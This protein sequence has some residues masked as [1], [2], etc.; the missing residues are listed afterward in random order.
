MDAKVALDRLKDYE[1]FLRSGEEAWLDVETILY[2][3]ELVRKEIEQKAIANRFFYRC[4]NCNSF[5]AWNSEIRMSMVNRCG[6]CGQKVYIKV[7]E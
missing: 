1:Y 4:P 6:E 5:V 3:K 2:L 7:D